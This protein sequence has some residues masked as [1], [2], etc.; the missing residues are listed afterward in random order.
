MYTPEQ[1]TPWDRLNTSP[2]Q[3]GSHRVFPFQI[4]LTNQAAA[5]TGGVVSLVSSDR[6]DWLTDRLSEWVN[7][8]CTWSCLL[9]LLPLLPFTCLNTESFTRWSGIKGF[10]H[11][12]SIFPL[13]LIFFF[14]S[15]ICRSLFFFYFSLSK[16]NFSNSHTQTY[17]L[18]RKCGNSGWNAWKAPQKMHFTWISEAPWRK[19]DV[20]TIA[21]V[22]L[23]I[24]R[25]RNH[26]I[27]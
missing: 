20:H 27:Y 6:A 24:R 12:R 14:P 11:A 4:N 8:L 16:E 9:L 17:T 21:N 10:C 25:I 1:L 2:P 18:H 26:Y 3:P 7:A 22:G 23:G 13:L 19:R 5:A 15:F